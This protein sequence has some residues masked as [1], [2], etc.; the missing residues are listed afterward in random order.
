M[1]RIFPQDT[2]WAIAGKVATAALEQLAHALPVELHG[3]GSRVVAGENG[4]SALLVFGDLP[5]ERLAKQL[6]VTVTPVYLLDFDDHAPVTLKLDRKKGHVVETNIDKHPADLLEEQG[7]VAPGYEPLVSP[8]LMVGL[9]EETTPAE[10]QNVLEADGT[11]NPRIEFRAH[12]RG[13]LIIGDE[14]GVTP[15]WLAMK[16]K[17]RTYVLFRNPQD[18]SFSCVLHEQGK[19]SAFSLGER[20][21]N[22]IPLDNILGETTLEG[23]LHVLKIPGELLGL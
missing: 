10:A 11:L 2:Q 17:R 23:I 9:V 5:S 20:D 15:A 13:V 16:L 1:I 12:P 21:A 14:F 22:A 4:F 7:I 3:E 19:R 8:V 6:L 18:G